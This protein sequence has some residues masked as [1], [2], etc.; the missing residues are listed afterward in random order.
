MSNYLNYL[1]NYVWL[2]GRLISSDLLWC[3]CFSLNSHF[4]FSL[5]PRSAAEPGE[6]FY[7]CFHFPLFPLLLFVTSSQCNMQFGG[8]MTRKSLI[9][10]TNEQ[11]TCMST[12]LMSHILS[13]TC[14]WLTS[15]FGYVS[16]CSIVQ[17]I[18]LFILTLT[19]SEYT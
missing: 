13:L 1:R 14:V 18:V 17:I 11:D 8:D 16:V 7:S 10:K 12:P 19:V 3:L 6:F 2:I 4:T 15:I 5:E 9:N